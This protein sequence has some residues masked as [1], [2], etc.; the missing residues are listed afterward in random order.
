MLQASFA[1]T[2]TLVHKI[3]VVTKTNQ[4]LENG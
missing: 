3:S 1:T 2:E 4:K